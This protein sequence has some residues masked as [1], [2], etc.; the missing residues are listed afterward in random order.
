MINFI[1]RGLLTLIF[2]SKYLWFRSKALESTEV[3]PYGPEH[4]KIAKWTYS[5]EKIA[6]EKIVNEKITKWKNS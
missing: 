4:E 5:Y 3:I 6:N 2:L 1:I